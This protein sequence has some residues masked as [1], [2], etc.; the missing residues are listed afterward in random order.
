MA[1]WQAHLSSHIL[2]LLHKP[3]LARAKDVFELRRLMKSPPFRV[4]ADIQI[5]AGSVGGILGEWIC[6]SQDAAATLL[7]LHGG[8]YLAM[9][10]KTHR[11]IT[12]AF[13]RQ[14]FRVFAPEYRLAPE[15]QFP[16]A[17]DDAV[18]CYEGMLSSPED[19]RT[20]V[21]AG[22]SAGGGLSVA[23][24]LSLRDAGI[25]PPFGMRVVLPLDGS[26][27]DGK[28]YHFE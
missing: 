2:R 15:H 4:P 12:I 23:L 10:P 16:A 17:I 22:D 24:L 11:P 28:I 19:Q 27:R 6:A 8:G 1:T 3:R 7:Y 18:R 25:P 20:L 21:I 14:G 26:C 13:A 5:S 9:S